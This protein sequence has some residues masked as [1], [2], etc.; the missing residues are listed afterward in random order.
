MS[1]IEYRFHVKHD[2]SDSDPII[3]RKNMTGEK[4]A[5]AMT[6]LEQ[7]VAFEAAKDLGKGW[8]VNPYLFIEP[9]EIVTLADTKGSGAIKHIWLTPTGNWRMQILRI[10][11]DGSDVPSVE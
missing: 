5:G 8:K 7:G 1:F 2:S 4:G 3:A 9:G 10:Y 11:W 6:E